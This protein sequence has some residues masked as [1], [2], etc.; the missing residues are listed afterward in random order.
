VLELALKK[1]C[2]AGSK[3][4]ITVE[5]I[6]QMLLH[7]AAWLRWWRRSQV[8]WWDPQH[9]ATS[10]ARLWFEYEG[11]TTA[12]LHTYLSLFG[13]LNILINLFA[14]PVQK[15]ESC[16]SYKLM[17]KPPNGMIFNHL[18]LL[19]MSVCSKKNINIKYG[20]INKYKRHGIIN[21][22]TSKQQIIKTVVY[23]FFFI[24]LIIDESTKYFVSNL[25]Y[26][27]EQLTQWGFENSAPKMGWLNWSY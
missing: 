5:L 13:R 19:N 17:L 14:A 11:E 25:C 4:N 23:T 9:A 12:A 7:C 8:L 2:S 10:D 22:A 21:L 3:V 24:S 26:N 27:P 20:F 18:L 15:Q 16:A 1:C 6:F